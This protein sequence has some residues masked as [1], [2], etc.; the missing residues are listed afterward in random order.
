MLKSRKKLNG[1]GTFDII[2]TVLVVLITF[3][4]LYPLYFCVVASF[5]DPNEVSLGHTFFFIKGFN[6]EA[7]LNVIKEKRLWMG[8]RNTIIYT[9]G[10]TLYNLLLHI[11]LGYALT[12]KYLPFR[13]FFSMYF[14]VT[15]YVAGGLIPSYLINKSL[16]LVNNPL[17][18][19]IGATGCYHMIIIRNFF[20]S[21]ID[22]Q[23]Y[24]AAY[25]DGASEG[26]T[27]WKIAIPLAK[28]IIAVEA[29]YYIVS[30]WNDYY[31]ALIYLYKEKYKPLQGVLRDILINN[32]EIH[33]TGFETADEVEALIRKAYLAQSMK[34]SVIIVAC[35]PLL[36]I[37]PF[38]QK[39][40]TKGVMIGAVKG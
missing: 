21:S 33:L 13:N 10:S 14:F 2:N 27:F 23:I 11:P 37:Y 31:T 19:I 15:M 22:S 32:S 36:I 1:Y 16:G 3:V 5:S 35:I 12:K 40:F 8:Y 7:W 6:T 39:Y 17:I 18:M 34:Y 24:E 28:P 25:I 4:I 20:S 29:L 9:T 30:K 38:I 26:Q